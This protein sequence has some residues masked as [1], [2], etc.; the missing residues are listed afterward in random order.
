MGLTENTATRLLALD[1]MAREFAYGLA[2]RVPE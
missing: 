1:V 2:N